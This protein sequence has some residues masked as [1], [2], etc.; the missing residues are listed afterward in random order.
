MAEQVQMDWRRLIAQQKVNKIMVTR[1]DLRVSTRAIYFP[2]WPMNGIDGGYDGGQHGVISTAL[3]ASPGRTFHVLRMRHMMRMRIPSITNINIIFFITK[4]FPDT[5]KG[6][7][8]SLRSAILQNNSLVSPG[9][10]WWMGWCPALCN[11]PNCLL[12][13]SLYWCNWVLVRELVLP[14]WN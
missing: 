13:T 8:F 14:K 6:V 9:G 2:R 11:W 1:N 7:R 12:P 4:V 10:H 3:R 5:G